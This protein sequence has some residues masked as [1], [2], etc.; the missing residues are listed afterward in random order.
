MD[1]CFDE[2]VDP[3]DAVELD[4]LVLVVSPIT[5]TGHVFSAGIVF[6]VAF[7]QYHVFV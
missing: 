1:I 7:S 4:L 6:F 2:D 5:H 3:A